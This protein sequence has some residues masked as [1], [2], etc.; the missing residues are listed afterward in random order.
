MLSGTIENR[1]EDADV[2][3]SFSFFLLLKSFFSSCDLEFCRKP[4][5]KSRSDAL[6]LM[7]QRWIY[8]GGYILVDTSWMDNIHWIYPGWIYAGYT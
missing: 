8:P 2:L 4:L 7:G 3:S 1:R 5:G 6:L